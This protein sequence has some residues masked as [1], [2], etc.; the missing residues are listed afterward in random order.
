MTMD[1]SELLLW[2]AL[3]TSS[4]A[5]GSSTPK[6]PMSSALGAPPTPRLEGFA[7]PVDTSSQASPQVSIP[8]NAEPDD[9]TLEEISLP[10]KTLRLGTSILPRDVI[11]LQEEVGKALGCL[12]VTRS[13]LNAYKRKH[14]SDFEMAL[15]QKP[16]RPLKRSGFSAPIP[17]GKLRPTDQYY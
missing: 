15:H 9:L 3:D 10:V 7:K 6:R 11:Q 13:S 16:P 12:L 14:V 2:V 4:Q 17:P 5:L 1:V 8:G